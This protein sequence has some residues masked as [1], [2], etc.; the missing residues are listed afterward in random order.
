MPFARR[1]SLALASIAALTATASATTPCSDNEDY[2]KATTR[3]GFR[4]LRAALKI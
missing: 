2:G 3:T 4:F 1:I